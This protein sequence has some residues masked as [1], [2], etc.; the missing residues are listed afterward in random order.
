MPAGTVRDGP[1]AP[2]R[3]RS[4]L[5]RWQR[6]YLRPLPHQ[7]GSLAFTS[8]T[9]TRSSVAVSRPVAVFPGRR[10][11]PGSTALRGSRLPPAAGRADP[12]VHL[13]DED[14]GGLAGRDPL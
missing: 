10:P 9:F 5:A 6:L 11:P 12:G 13:P 4:W 8:T 1:T 2:G 3:S 7:Q 14:L